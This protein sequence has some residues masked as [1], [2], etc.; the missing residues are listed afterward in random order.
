MIKQL[1]CKTTCPWY[2]KGNKA[3]LNNMCPI[4]YHSLYPYFLGMFYGLKKDINVCCPAEKSVDV[5][6]KK[7]KNNS[8]FNVPKHWKTVIYAEVVKVNGKCDFNHK[9]G[10]R[11]FF[12]G[13]SQCKYICPAGVNNL[14]PFLKIKKPKC[15]NLKKL[16]CPD[17]KENIYYCIKT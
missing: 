11:F 8:K 17:W 5:W 6:V 1:P 14:F 15:I 12:P 9:V 2:M 16:R 10:D 3:F 4:M 7:R 13:S